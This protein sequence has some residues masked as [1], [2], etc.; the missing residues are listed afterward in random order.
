MLANM[1]KQNFNQQVPCQ[2]HNMYNSNP[3]MVPQAYYADA[4]KQLAPVYVQPP[5][6]RAY[7]EQ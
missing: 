7:D 4:P 2:N 6:Y 1:F 5:V 3:G